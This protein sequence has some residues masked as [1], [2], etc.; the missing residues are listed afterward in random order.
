MVAA[1]ALFNDPAMSAETSAH[2]PSSRSTGDR[3]GVAP[4]HELRRWGRA[5]LIAARNPVDARELVLE[6]LAA[7]RRDPPRSTELQSDSAWQNH[8]HGLL[9]VAWPCGELEAFAELWEETVNSLARQGLDVGRGAYCGWDDADR[10][11]ARAAWCLTR[12]LRPRAV[13]ETG[14]ARGVTTR[15]ILE[16]L[17]A[18]GAGRLCSIDL[19]P[20]L[21]EP[22]PGDETGAA[23]AQALKRRWTL[24]QGSS[25]R[26]LPTLLRELGTIDLFIHD[27]RHSRR[28]VSFELARAWQALNPGGF[29]LVDD[30]HRNGAFGACVRS[31][32]EPAAIVCASDD[33]EG[34]FGLIQKPG[35][36][37]HRTDPVATAA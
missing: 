30:V 4:K 5:A 29:L 35:A 21:R 24:V 23:V 6:R 8:L 28:N 31:F 16:A 32:G 26:R 14:V 12:H 37:S 27:S 1:R 18:N 20:V 13:V 19:P 11:F 9:T 34:R 25:R 22:R 7:M 33:G 3:I 10:G 2:A 15:V 17:Q 36:A